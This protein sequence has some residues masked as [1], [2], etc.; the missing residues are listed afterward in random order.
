MTA[1]S[2]ASILLAAVSALQAVLTA[3]CGPLFDRF[4]QHLLRAHLDED[5]HDELGLR[6]FLKNP[7]AGAMRT[8][9]VI[10]LMRRASG[11]TAT[12]AT[13]LGLVVAGIFA[14]VAGLSFGRGVLA[15]CAVAATL[16]AV[17]LFVALLIVA[18]LG[19]VSEYRVGSAARGG[20]RGFLDTRCPTTLTFYRDTSLVLGCALIAVTTAMTI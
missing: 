20:V 1:A 5:R 18:A 15:W 10:L 13:L 12:L 2:A 11:V 17:A 3:L 19:R 14:T 4:W 7:D 16:G 6:A 9:V 8:D